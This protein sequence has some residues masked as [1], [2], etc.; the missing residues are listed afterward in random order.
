MSVYAP[1]SIPGQSNDLLGSSSLGAKASAV[2]SGGSSKGLDFAGKD[3]DDS[4][5]QLKDGQKA[6]DSI[7]NMKSNLGSTKDRLLNAYDTQLSKKNAQIAGNR[8][9][10]EKNQT[11]GLREQAET[12]RKSIFDASTRFGGASSSVAGTLAR[13]LQSGMGKNRQAVLTQAGDLISAQNQEATNATDSH[14]LSR[15]AVYDWED[16]TK[17]ELENEFQI[18][19]A[20][21]NRLKDK[22]PSWKKADIERQSNANLSS[23]MGS[24]QGIAQTARAARDKINMAISE[25]LA[26]A[27]AVDSAS[28]NIDTPAELDTPEF[29]DQFNMNPDG[30][31]DPNATD[32]YNPKNTNKKRV[33]T[34]IFGNPLIIDDQQQ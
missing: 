29:S 4:S 13:S 15:K 1:M 12:L 32:F 8:Q 6:V 24:L 17:K 22:V 10:I 3:W 18:S 33:G 11:K 5:S 28:I 2:S 27:N 7:V 14:N 25:K 21:L 30:Q 31:D 9:V 34:D 23:F 20:A 26:E 16:M 19:Q